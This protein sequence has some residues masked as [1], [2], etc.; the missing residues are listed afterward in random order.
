MIQMMMAAIG[1]AS[2][3]TSEPAARSAQWRREQLQRRQQA[4]LL[5]RAMGL[6]IVAIGF[7]V[8]ASRVL[9]HAHGG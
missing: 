6:A 2:P 5:R 7:A 8:I 4:D 1:S 9:Q 3:V